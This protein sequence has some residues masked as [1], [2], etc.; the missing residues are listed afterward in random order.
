MFSIIVPLY[1]K[2]KY[3][4]KA[5]L[6]ILSQTFKEFEIIVVNDG[7]SD[8]SLQCL[9]QVTDNLRFEQPDVY[10]NVKII[11]QPNSGVSTAR[12][13]GVKLAKYEY[14]AF[15][16]AD[17]WWD[18]LYLEE[19]RKLIIDY[20]QAAVYGSSYFI[21]KNEQALAAKIGVDFKQESGLINYCKVY[22]KTMYMPLWTGATIVRKKYFDLENGF[23]PALK[24][25]EDFDLWVR[26]AL[27]YPVAFVNKP[28]AFYNQDVELMGRAIGSKLYKPNEHMLFSDYS[29]FRDNSE[30]QRLFQQLAVYG[31]L[32]YYLAGENTEELHQILE[33]I[34]WSEHN[35][36]YKLYYK[37]LP[38]KIVK[39]W[40]V[41]LKIGSKLKKFLLLGLIYFI[42][43]IL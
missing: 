10:E 42:Y 20:P 43:L 21:V 14:I 4:Q 16:D 23:K 11:T 33:T 36:R 27:K 24:L 28:L 5:I 7:S 22:A 3:I 26:V 9:E 18:S 2:E 25:G 12:N 13:N 34:N 39:I 38:K 1:N 37:V 31:L 30:F 29:E 35:Y 19:M 32:P 40:F 41:L 6:S 8:K 15:L 17:D